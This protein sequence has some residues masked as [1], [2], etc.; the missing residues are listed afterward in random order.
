[1][2]NKTKMQEIKKIDFLSLGKILGIIYIFI[3]LVIGVIY[4]IVSFIN[5][6]LGTTEIIYFIGLF[7]I[8]IMPIF[9]GVLGFV[10]GILSAIIYNIASS[11][12]GGIKIELR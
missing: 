11:K 4:S 7:S 8:I 5:V 12:I 2:K 6:L 3:G 10:S 1:M 9:Y